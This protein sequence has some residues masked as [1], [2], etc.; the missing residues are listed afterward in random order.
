MRYYK[1]KITV[2]KREFYEDLRDEYAKNPKTGKCGFFKEGQEFIISHKNYITMM[3]GKFCAYAWEAINKW[4]YA[5]IQGGP[6]MPSFM[7]NE[8]VM[9]TCC[10]DGIRPVIFKIERIT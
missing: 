6:L 1:C 9:I 7:K 8:K 2:L 3:D 4:I 10:N 5:A